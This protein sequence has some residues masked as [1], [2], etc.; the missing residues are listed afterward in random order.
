MNELR[1]QSP[2]LSL[3][4]IVVVSGAIFSGSRSTLD[5][6]IL[7]A[8]FSLMALSVGISFGQAGMMSLGQASFA[9][10]GAYTTSI[11]TTQAGW[12][13]YAGLVA[14]VL[15]PPLIAYPLARLLVRLS[16]LALA[17]ATLFLGEIVMIV[18]NNGGDLTGGY[19]GIGGIPPIS[20][21]TTPLAFH[22]LAWGCVVVTVV[23]YSNLKSSAAGRA[24]NTL[25]QDPLRAQ[26][27][28]DDG[29][30]RLSATF[31]FSAG[32]CGL[33]GWLYAHYLTYV[34]PES[35]SV[36]TSISVLLMVIVGGSRYVLGPVVG[37]AL[38][39]VLNDH[40]PAEVLGLLYG[41]A[42]VI[43]LVVAPRGVMGVAAQ[44]LGRFRP[45]PRRPVEDSLSDRPTH[46]LEIAP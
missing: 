33:A 9:A 16:H 5:T 46:E 28:G 10:I 11:L 19:L 26:A 17:L 7:I 45:H 39:T 8:I 2:A 22:F 25:R 40:L 29:P 18:L 35:L 3:L 1:R 4:L 30:H 34:A 14:A 43:V 21:A 41:L 44:L 37:A 12:S 6:S 27:D 24:L 23:L 20:L 15:V 13:P 38:L 36:S 31:A 42:L 32:L